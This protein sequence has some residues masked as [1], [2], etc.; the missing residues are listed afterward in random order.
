[1]IGIMN[2]ALRHPSSFRDPSG[3]VFKQDGKIYR[4]VNQSYSDHYRLLQSSGLYGRLTGA[5]KLITHTEL[6]KNLLLSDN[7]FLTLLPE[8]IDFISYPYEWC[9]DQLKDA[10]LLTLDI[11]RE[12]VAHG[13]ILKDATP[14]NIQFIGA[15]PVFIDSLSFEKYDPSAP[16]VAYRQFTECFIAPLAIASYL[17]IDSTKLIQVY[18]DGIPL[19]TAEKMLP[20]R[21]RFNLPL[22]LHIFLQSR[23]M[24][25]N[26]NRRPS[27]Y[28]FSERK[29]INIIQHL[30]SLVN[31]F[32]L[33]KK[34]ST[35]SGYYEDSKLSPQYIQ[36]KKEHVT[37][38]LEMAGSRSILDVG[39]NEGLFSFL[40]AQNT[41]RKVLAIDA[42]SY[43]VNKLYSRCR[44]QKCNN[45]VSLCIDISNPTPPTGWCNQER[46]SFFERCKIDTVLALALIHHLAI[47]KN[48]RLED[49][50]KTFNDIADYLII[51]FVPKE[52]ERV[53]EMLLHRC[54]VF[55]SYSIE[56]FEAVFKTYFRLM[57]KEKVGG[58]LRWIYLF[59]RD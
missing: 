17:N 40:S 28:H 48:I 12:A 10:A 53:K 55:S 15:K 45:V 21:S 19:S 22:Y 8:Q 30:R 56:N 38:F 9:F 36:N 7:W 20:V 59:H 1:M 42:D 2:K 57:A 52:D 5:G 18:P 14:F 11:A 13:M 27:N 31:S 46:E 44:D 3:F 34:K 6:Q 16:W 37:T 33:S 35:W 43:C 29:M 58:T 54:D 32:K 24:Y 25:K 39:S 26:N 51:E 23:L 47:G 41:H 49:I 4:Q 50:A